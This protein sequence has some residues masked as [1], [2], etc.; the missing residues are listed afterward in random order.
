MNVRI[1]FS[2]VFILGA[3]KLMGISL[4]MEDRDLGNGFLEA[5]MGFIIIIFLIN[6]VD[7]IFRKHEETN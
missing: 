6:I 5:S 3:Y 4:R 7:I 2:L 1:I